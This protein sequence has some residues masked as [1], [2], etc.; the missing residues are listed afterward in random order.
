LLV[1]WQ[2]L[3]LCSLNKLWRWHSPFRSRS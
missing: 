3:N 2:H 1:V